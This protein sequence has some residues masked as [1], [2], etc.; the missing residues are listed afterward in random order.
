[1]NFGTVRIT[2]RGESVLVLDHLDDPM[3]VKRT[4]ESV[5]PVTEPVEKDSSI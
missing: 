4:I 5:R 3:K 1:L 2:G